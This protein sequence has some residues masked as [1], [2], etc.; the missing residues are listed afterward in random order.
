[1][2]VNVGL[3]SL[4][5]TKFRVDIAQSYLGAT[6]AL[7]RSQSDVEVSV[8]PKVVTEEREVT[9]AVDVL[10]RDKVDMIIVQCGTFSMG[11]TI[12]VL[13][14]AIPATPLFLWGFREPATPGVPAL[15][16]NSLCGLNMSASFLYKLRRRFSALYAS[17]DEEEAKTTVQRW[18]AAIRLR[19]SLRRARFC[20]I[21]ERA[22]GFYRAGVDE[23]RFTR[24]IG[25]E[26]IYH[27]VG[28]VVEAARRY[29]DDE[30]S[31]EVERIYGEVDLVEATREAVERSARVYR[32]VRTLGEEHDVAAF[33]IRCWPEF[34]TLYRVA[35]CGVVSRLNNEGVVV[36]CEGD[37]PALATMVIQDAISDRPPFLADLV[38]MTPE[39]VVK[40]WH[41]GPAA[42]CLA[43]P[44]AR[45]RYIEHPT[46]KE[47]IGMA[48]DFPLAG[49][50]VTM[51]KLSEDEGCY[52][53]LIAP[54][55]AVRPD[56]ELSGNH[57]DIVFDCGGPAL[58]DAILSHGIEH[59]YSIA[60]GDDT[61]TL[62]EFCKWSNIEPVLLAGSDGAPHGVSSAQGAMHG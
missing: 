44:T 28:E 53:L 25:P 50:R 16:L 18:I 32:A 10:A 33:A 19:K 7:L 8:V 2:N 40:A 52:K 1:M 27:S 4:G 12:V 17:V 47:G 54:G 9:H 59:H 57:V 56:R 20:S 15:P 11:R 58:L 42:R 39:G 41:C 36:S 24:T 5:F 62:L 35:V 34:Q 3:V 14:E 46:I 61:A 26:I 43:D 49:G 6:E 31:E 37:I 23:L 22:P 60:Y 48:A 13:A 55:T 38:N 21:G 45:T 51:A 29:T 30:V